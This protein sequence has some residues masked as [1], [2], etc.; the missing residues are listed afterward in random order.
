MKERYSVT[1]MTC[2][3]CSSHV[4]KAV[5]ACQGVSNVQ[6]NL[7][8]NSMVVEYD[9]TTCSPETIIHSVEEAG[10]GAAQENSGNEAKTAHAGN[11][12]QE[13][14]SR[15][16]EMR[17]RLI[18]S[19]VFL[20]LLMYVS[21]GH[22]MGF[23]LPMVFH[24][25]EN[26][27]VL[28]FTQFLL[29]LPILYL[30]RSYFSRGF[31][32]LLHRAPTMDTLIAVGSGAALLYGIAAMF[33]IGW[34]L[35][36]GNLELSHRYAMDLYF[37]SAG[38]ILTLITVGKY[39]ESRSKG[40]TS[41]A[42]NRLMDLAPRTALRMEGDREVEIPA[43]EI[44][45]GDIL[46]VKPGMSI[47]TDG[48]V[49]EGS[50]AVDES[51]V[52][53]ESLPVE[54]KPGDGVTGATIN[55]SGWMKMQ[56]ERVGSDTTLAQIIQLVEDATSSKAPIA[57]LADKVSAVFVPVVISLA[58]LTMAVW[59]L[60]G[61][62]LET[63]LSFGISVLVISCPCALGLATPTAIMVGTGRGAEKG[64]L[65]KS[66][67]SLETAHRIDTVVLDK[68]GTITQ[69]T[70]E[71]T[72]S[73][74]SP[75]VTQETFMSLAGSLEKLSEHPLAKAVVRWAEKNGGFFWEPKEFK[76]TEGRGISAVVDGKR[77]IAGNAPMMQEEGV[78]LSGFQET[79]ERMAS[80]GKTPLYFAADGKL[81]G[82]LALADVLKPG[83]RRAIQ[84]MKA[85]GLDVI[86]L[87]GDN[88]RTAEAVRKEL[89]LT[90]VSAELFPGDKEKEIRRLQGEGR[91]VAM[92]GD[93]IND[94]PSLARADLGIAVGAGTDVAIE[95]A[96]VV[97]MHNDL[98]DVPSAIQLGRSVIRNI[99]E[100]LFWAFFYNVLG[101]PLAA[102][103]LYPLF[104]IR[105][106]PMFAAAA[107]SFSSVFV[108]S[109][110]L[111]L[112]FFKPRFH[113]HEEEPVP[114]E[115]SGNSG[116]CDACILEKTADTEEINKSNP[117][118]SELQPTEAEN[119]NRNENKKGDDAVMFKKTI[120]IEGMMCAHCSGRVEKA[121]NAVPGVTAKVDL[122]KKCAV[123]EISQA[124]SDETLT[125]AVTDAGYEVVSIDG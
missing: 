102:G 71:V 31:K 36:H 40:K 98:M 86:M 61:S 39:L 120:H 73:F 32:S 16:K 15:A 44:Q 5:K 115:T 53:G 49:L 74:L 50:C 25:D 116:N 52:T 17:R 107:M 117:Y 67:E 104:Q 43:E 119:A 82:M 83:S 22:M 106:N 79:E 70:P 20:L 84:E 105:L 97:L 6:V 42:V 41:E 1:G 118:F 76:A 18:L 28:A 121:L 114:S 72:D 78:S 92:V 9:D 101:I 58:V 12:A 21:M 3:A 46:V 60:A 29:L 85:L 45:V 69:G 54:K 34:A 19:V 112:R 55:R 13:A 75:D 89:G 7:L 94:A 24:G 4:E 110:A 95:S 66:A 37:E 27:M 65:F 26:A 14:V 100:N 33:I 38:T 68:T 99:K 90:A 123:V 57:R 96:D 47:P 80:S 2:S 109:N 56:A 111:R 122:E 48:K 91:K 59:L 64:I 63:A 30:N 124:V 93:G 8:Q 81:L 87:T 62:P 77:V 88:R 125:K 23:P 103:V 51:A 35:G 11:P 113:T 108:V 10:Y